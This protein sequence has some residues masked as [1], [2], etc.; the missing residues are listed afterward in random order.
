M[1]TAA[2]LLGIGVFLG[3]QR[4]LSLQSVIVL[5]LSFIAIQVAL[6]WLYR[7]STSAVT[8]AAGFMTDQLSLGNDLLERAR[9]LLMALLVVLIG[10]SS[11]LLQS[12]PWRADDLRNLVPAKGAIATVEGALTASPTERHG[13]L[14]TRWRLQ[15]DVSA[16]HL[17]GKW[18]PASGQVIID[19]PLAF[20]GQFHAGQIMR[21]D[22]VLIPPVRASFPGGYDARNQWARRGVHFQLRPDA[23]SSWSMPLESRK[24]YRPL[25]DHF[26]G[27]A[28]STVARG[29]PDDEAVELL[30]AMSLGWRTALT[31]ETAAPFMQSG[32]MHLFAISGLHVALVAGV[33]IS[34]LRVCRVPRQ[35]A[36]A[37]VIPALW[38]YACAT[39]WQPSAV[40]ATIMMTLIL[41]AWLFKRPV[42]VLN[43]VG[44][45]A[46]LILLWEP[47]QLFRPSFQLSFGVVFSLALFVSPLINRLQPWM[48]PDSLLP[49][50]LW[51][52]WWQWLLLPGRVL[53]G[54]VVVSCCAW[55]ASAPLVAHHFNLFNP[56]ALLANVPAVVC[57]SAA[58][59]SC[60][61]SLATG[62]WWPAL[63]E[64]F[65][66]SAW[67]FMRCMMSVSEG[68]AD[69]PGAWQAVR[70]PAWWMMVGWYGLLFGWGTRWFLKENL[71][72][73]AWAGTAVFVVALVGS[74]HGDRQT[75][76][77]T[78]L[79]GEPVT[80][81]EGDGGLLVDSGSPRTVAFTLPRHLRVRGEDSLNAIVL[82]RS[83][84]H[85]VEG[86]PDLLQS[87]PIQM[88][89]LSHAH[90]SSP[91]HKT[92]Q[93]VLQDFNG[94]RRVAAGDRVGAWHVLHPAQGDDF[95]RGTDDAIVLRGNF[96]G[97]R[98]LL[99]SDLGRDGRQALAGR[100]DD[101]RAEVL[102]VSLPDRSP[103]VD[104]GF[105][106]MVQPRVIVV[107]DAEF[108][109]TE[110]APAQWLARLRASG[111]QVISIR[112]TGGVRLS[113]WPGG[114]QLENSGGI[115]FRR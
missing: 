1:L 101:L 102:V 91:I 53:L 18:G 62:A 109:N 27:W 92:V 17:D 114:W 78:F 110:Q 68:A 63:S 50:A 83:V 55:M 37:V 79:P 52:R 25:S 5:S 32:T 66:H 3:D 97:V 60:L 20:T 22:G 59:A 112:Q 42:N 54:L 34:L 2:V 90:S 35:A 56:V 4:L 36:A 16:I 39:G 46:F 98:V 58:L 81:V 93:S 47:Q 19:T 7:R 88:V 6:H 13:G 100:D 10:W 40:R 70:S 115:L 65:N 31:E 111:A 21:V 108:P 106:K 82:S 69:Q 73:W 51:L 71:R 80:H 28:R 99:L 29:L 67:F 74:W 107:Q 87:Q 38:F 9:A 96:Y 48:E 43:S 44:A 76:A 95:L 26:R 49:R 61:G 84:K 8:G 75:V 89:H 64:L 105:V 24:V 12:E 23:R 103:P 33:I 104:L 72:R 113:I 41:S 15:F 14:T 94:T 77:M 85:H 57:G 86:L 30:W 11:F 45:A